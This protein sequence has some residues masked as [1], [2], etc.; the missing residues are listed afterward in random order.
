MSSDAKNMMPTI[1]QL[2]GNS[3]SSVARHEIERLIFSGKLQPGT[4]LSESAL[5]AELGVSRGPIREACRALVGVGLLEL[6]AGKG[7]Y[8]RKLDEKDAIE[9]YDLRGGFLSLGGYL[10]AKIITEDQL[11]ILTSLHHKIGIAS[12]KG[13]FKE[14]SS[15]NLAFHRKAIE[16]TGNSRLITEYDSTVKEF[17]LCRTHGM[18][19]SVS[20]KDSH[21]EHAAILDAFIE[22]DPKK[23]YE[24][25]LNHVMNGKA[26][27]LAALENSKI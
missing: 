1:S 25:S 7:V 3:L 24:A 2:Q 13:N 20:L 4:R 17:S 14:F 5:A 10:L 23:A 19:N 21:K 27:L 6:V 16:F 22:R 11:E 15:L 8:I 18:S 9:I 26:R 12:E